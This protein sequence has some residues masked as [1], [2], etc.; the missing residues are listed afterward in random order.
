MRQQMV[1][2]RSNHFR[3]EHHLPSKQRVGGSNPSRGT[4]IQNRADNYFGLLEQ[5]SYSL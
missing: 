3:R 2:L 1:P 4:T 5:D